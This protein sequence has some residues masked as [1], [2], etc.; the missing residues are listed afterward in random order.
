MKSQVPFATVFLV[1]VNFVN[2][3]KCLIGSAVIFVL[4]D[5][6]YCLLKGIVSIQQHHQERLKLKLGVKNQYIEIG[7]KR[8]RYR[9]IGQ[10][11]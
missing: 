11:S 9:D 8:M 3:G 1:L 5:W 4:R 7:L 10:L 6:D 2:F